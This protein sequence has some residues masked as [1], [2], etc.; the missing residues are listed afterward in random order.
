MDKKY[1]VQ[2]KDYAE[3]KSYW[4]GHRSQS[5]ET[6]GKVTKYNVYSKTI[7]GPDKWENSFSSRQEAEHWIKR[8]SDKEFIDTL[9]SN[10]NT[11]SSVLE[12]DAEECLNK[13]KELVPSL[14]ELKKTAES[15]GDLSRE[16]YNL[17][18]KKARDN[19]R[20]IYYSDIVEKIIRLVRL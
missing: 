8:A 5:Y 14:L 1:Y 3:E 16:Y 7:E 18:G 17:T 12:K 10:Y 20:D 11:L 2:A 13:I 15:V 4:D 6:G 19:G 9:F